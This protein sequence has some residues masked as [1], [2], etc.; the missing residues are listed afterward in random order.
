M[1]FYKAAQ[2]APYMP[3]FVFYHQLSG[4]VHSFFPS[5]ISLIR[6][7]APVG[8]TIIQSMYPRS[9]PQTGTEVSS[10][11]FNAPIY[12]FINNVLSLCFGF[13]VH[14]EYRGNAV[15]LSSQCW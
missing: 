3:I 4:Q 7:F 1:T 15:I 13:V 11:W 6:S 14:V 10:A 8:L 5:F 9:H 12:K 2:S